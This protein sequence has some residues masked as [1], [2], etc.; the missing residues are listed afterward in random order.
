MLCD[1]RYANNINLR[2]EDKLIGMERFMPRSPLGMRLVEQRQLV[3]AI[4]ARRHASNL[5]VFGSVVRGEDRPGSDVDLLVDLEDPTDLF[6]LLGLERELEEVLGVRVDADTTESLRPRVR[7][8]V[9]AE[10][11]IL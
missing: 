6:N 11:S 1:R 4:A 10:A 8:E 7:A 2:A 9:L 3:L 5:R